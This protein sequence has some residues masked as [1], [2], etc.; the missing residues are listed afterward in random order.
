MGKEN[1]NKED[2]YHQSSY[3]HHEKKKIKKYG[4]ECNDVLDYYNERN[5][6]ILHYLLKIL[7]F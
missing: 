2:E 7:I 6:I 4:Y 5:R 3:Q 1:E